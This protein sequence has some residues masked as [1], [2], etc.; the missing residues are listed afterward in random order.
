MRN[1]RP[2]QAVLITGA[3][4]GIGLQTAL[5]LH[6]RGYRVW[7]TARQP[8]DLDRLTHAG[9][10]A[11][12]L[13]M[14]DS[15]QIRSVAAEVLSATD[16]RLWGLFNNAGY[17]QPGAVED[18]SRDAL[19]EQFESNFFGAVELTNA[20]LPAMRAAGEGRIIQNSSVLGFAAMPYRG[21]YNASKFALEG[22]T[23]TLRLELQGSGIEVSLIEPGPI[24]TRFRENALAAFQRHIDVSNSAHREA[25]ERVLARL[26]ARANNNRFAL[27]PQAVTDCVV[28]ALES[29]RPKIRYRVTTPTKTFAVLKRLLPARV[30]DRLL[31]SVRE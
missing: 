16:N 15:E 23:D 5:H 22:I 17:G 27:D 25:Y 11:L 19:R 1:S 7:A 9:I 8:A 30:L 26:E 6:E 31:G 2:D 3:S 4:S 13:D 10:R 12:P 28:H 29:P 20:L 21:A 24:R 14:R 18:L